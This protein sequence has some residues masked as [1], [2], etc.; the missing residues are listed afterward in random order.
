M[1][2]P[3]GRVR[4]GCAVTRDESLSDERIKHLEFIQGIISRLSANSFLIK[5]WAITVAGA[6]YAY[7]ASHFNW[8]VASVSLLPTFAFWYLDSYFLRQERLFRC[9]YNDVRRAEHTTEP[10]SMS[11]TPYV[12]ANPIWKAAGSRTLW[13]L[14]GLILVVGVVLL[15]GS[16]KA[17]SRLLGLRLF[18][19]SLLY[20]IS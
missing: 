5:G 15:V 20:W 19:R 7:T 6:F 10:F 13:P 3:E 4:Y 12:K 2:R 16:L 1:I 11:V 8:R 18:M 14:Y 17:S 9:L